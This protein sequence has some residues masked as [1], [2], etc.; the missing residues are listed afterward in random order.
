MVSKDILKEMHF[1]VLSNTFL[2]NAF[3]QWFVLNVCTCC[4]KLIFV[5]KKYILV[6]SWY[7]RKEN[8]FRNCYAVIR[9]VFPSK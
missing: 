6:Y 3:N 5:R 4:S 8:V 2:L 7:T 1:C 9:I